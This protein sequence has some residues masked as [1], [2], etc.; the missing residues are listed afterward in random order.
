MEGGALKTLCDQAQSDNAKLRLNS[1]WALKNIVAGASNSTKMTCLKELGPG[2]LKHIVANDLEDSWSVTNPHLTDRDDGSSTPIRMNTPNAAGEQVDLL[3]AVSE[4]STEN[5]QD[6]EGDEE[7]A[8]KMSDSIGA[9]AKGGRDRKQQLWECQPIGDG[10]PGTP[11]GEFGLRPLSQRALS[12]EL[13]IQKEGLDFIRNLICGE[14]S[15]DMIDHLFRELGQDKMF[16]L[17]TTKLRPRIFNAF[18]RDRRSSENGVRHVQPHTEIVASTCFT[19]VHIACGHPKHRQLLISQ[20][21]LLKLLLPL[22]SHSCREVRVSLCWFIINVTWVEDNADKSNAK[23]RARELAKLGFVE[24]LDAL[25]KDESL[26]CRETAKN[27][28]DQMKQL[29]HL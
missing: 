12:D 18:T 14:H 27:A 11:G 24:K 13:A 1:L 9:L 10:F 26:D 17:L 3:N 21:E 6:V 4:N 8:L 20:T 25:E 28:R 2:W 22:F 7:E 15:P 29:L 19:L 16:E 23:V 5:G